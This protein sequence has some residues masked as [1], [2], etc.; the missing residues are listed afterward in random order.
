[1][2]T[3]KDY[4][5]GLHKDVVGFSEELT[6]YFPEAKFTSGF[7][8]NAVT[9]FGKKSKHGIGQAIDLHADDKLIEY[10]NSK[11]GVALLHKYKLGMLDET[12][13]ENKK[14]GNAVH[15]G[16]DV[17]LVE[18]NENKY[19]EL[20]GDQPITTDVEVFDLPKQNSTFVSVPDVY[21]EPEKDK[22]IEEVKAK[23]QE[24]NFI[25]A[26]QELLNKPQE[27]AVVQQEQEYQAPQVD[28]NDIYNQV[29]A[30]VSAQQGCVIK[31]NEGQRKYPNQ[32]T[33]I[34]GNIMA[35]DGYGDIVL[36]VIPDVGESKIVY[37][38]TGE[39][40]FKG[41]SKFIEIPIKNK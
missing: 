21:K 40:T 3:I 6:T 2:A 34:E 27:Q 29:D 11:D 30:F 33:E 18:R 5:D 32:V 24:A 31:D 26:Y 23:T 39:H 9:K 10:L 41:A 1:M 38:N 17:A 4:K 36:K 22:D 13:P 35:T 12:L 25:E 14:W 37:P 8:Q 15:I 28:L 7:R 16:S 19:K 20:F